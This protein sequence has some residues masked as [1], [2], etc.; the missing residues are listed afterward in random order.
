[1]NARGDLTQL[2][3]AAALSVDVG[4]TLQT[5]LGATPGRAITR[6]G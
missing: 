6:S 3:V 1:M 4:L 2:A 5:R